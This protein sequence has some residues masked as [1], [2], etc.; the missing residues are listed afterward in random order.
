MPYPWAGSSER[1]W[2]I[3]MSSVPCGMGKRGDG[4]DTST[5][6]HLAYILDR[7]KIKV[8]EQQNCEA[9]GLWAVSGRACHCSMI[10]A[11][12]TIPSPIRGMA[13]RNADLLAKHF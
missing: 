6:Y 9:D 4:I 11:H 1:I 2:R 13:A 8:S 7:S 5:F 3:S 12:A 10:G